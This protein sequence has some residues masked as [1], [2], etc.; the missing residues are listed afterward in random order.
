M[1]IAKRRPPI[2]AIAVLMRMKNIHIHDD[3]EYTYEYECIA[4]WKYASRYPLEI[5]PS[6]IPSSYVDKTVHRRL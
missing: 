5:Y 4:A 1:R 2:P 3:V 6:I